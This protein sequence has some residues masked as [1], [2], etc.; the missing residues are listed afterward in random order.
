MCS[1]VMGK[2]QDTLLA[3]YPVLRDCG[4]YT[5][6]RLGSGS[7]S[8]V[9]IEGPDTGITVPYLRDILNQDKLYIRPLQC[10]ISEED[11]QPYLEAVVSCF[12]F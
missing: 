9:E 7:R 8:L 1:T 12:W 6:L 11:V 2:L 4:G 10:D 3:S 5:L